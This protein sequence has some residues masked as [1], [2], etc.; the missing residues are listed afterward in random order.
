MTC[1]CNVLFNDFGQRCQKQ[2]KTFAN[3]VAVNLSDS[4]VI[5]KLALAMQ[6]FDEDDDDDCATV[7]AD[8]SNQE[9]NS[10]WGITFLC[11]LAALWKACLF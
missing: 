3:Q 7:A 6:L 9:S 1:S 5:E 8:E 11:Q 2:H 10:W 4:F